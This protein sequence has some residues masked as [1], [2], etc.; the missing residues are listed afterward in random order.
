MK[1][2][3]PVPRAEDAPADLFDSGHLWIQERIDGLHLR[4]RL[5][6][7]GVLEFGGRERVYGS[8]ADDVP[9]PYH[10]AVRHVREE[11]D[12]DALRASVEA[13]SSVVFFAEATVRQAIDYDW[14]RTPAVLGFDVWN[15]SDDR[16]LPPDSV[17]QVYDR[18]GLAPVNAVQKEVRAT[19][20]DPESYEI[21]DSEWYDGPAE[22]VVV[23]N[24]TGGRAVIPNPDFESDDAE[25]LSASADD[26]ADRYATRQRVEEVVRRLETRD[27]PVTFDAVFERAVEAIAREESHRFFHDGSSVEWSAFRS[28]FAGRT[29]E[30]LET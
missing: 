17:E 13:P 19:D 27:R 2:F 1:Q 10:H 18:L 29:Q 21:P 7:S 30:F 26:L 9:P 5:R 16:F 4:F 22:G 20:F 14:D 3:P 24:K 23:R 12:R 15:S 28:A 25:P 11:F 6:E 8:D